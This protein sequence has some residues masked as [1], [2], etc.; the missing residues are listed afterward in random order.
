MTT[1]EFFKNVIKW[2]QTLDTDLLGYL[3]SDEYYW[4]TIELFPGY[5]IIWLRSYSPDRPQALLGKFK[6]WHYDT[7][8][9]CTC[10]LDFTNLGLEFVKDDPYSSVAYRL[11]AEA[12]CI[13]CDYSIL[14]NEELKPTPTLKYVNYEKGI[15][16]K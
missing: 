11:L 9:L 12:N 4:D 16:N 6:G 1:L 14:T 5:N 10:H 2:Y 8:K 7:Y 15:Y 3:N 13:I